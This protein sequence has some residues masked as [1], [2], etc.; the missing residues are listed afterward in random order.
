MRTMNPLLLAAPLFAALLAV[1]ALAPAPASD[2]VGVYGLIDKVVLLPD[3][4]KPTEAEIHG[5]FAVARGYGEY[6]MAPAV[7]YLWF[8]AGSKPEEAVRQWRELAKQV[9]T[10]M[11]IGFASRYGL[12][13][14]PVIVT[15]AGAQKP[16]A[17]SAYDTEFGLGLHRTEG[18]DYGTLRELRLTP[19]PRTP[20]PGGSVKVK[21]GRHYFDTKLRFECDNCVAKQDGLTY[22]FEVEINGR[23]RFASPPIQPGDKVTAWDTRLALDV[24]DQVRWSVRVA[25][26][27]TDRVPV[28]TAHFKVE[29]E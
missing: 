21:A 2:P 20:A 24:G 22:V 9:G 27:N 11:P 14:S 8:S 5:T 6:S 23:D 10:G 16:A 28:A 7:G 29:A 15:P 4:Q 12:V 17:A 26:G 25:G 19:K 13:K 3:E 1:P 18:A